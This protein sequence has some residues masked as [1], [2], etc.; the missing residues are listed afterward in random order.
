MQM[1]DRR[2]K[3]V[4]NLSPARPANALPATENL[5]A[6]L[7]RP[8]PLFKRIMDICGALIGIILFAPIFI[9]V[10][11]ALKILS[12]GP[13]IF[14]QKR[15]GLGGRPFTMFKFRTMITGAEAIKKHLLSSNEQ[16]GPVFK[17]K[18]DP[19]VTPIGRILRKTSIDELPQLFN[20]LLGDMSLVGPRPPTLDEVAFYQP[21]QR[22]R[23]M[24]T[25]G[26]TCVWQVKGRAKG[27]F[28]EWV[29]M[30][31]FYIRSRSIFK[32]VMLIFMTIPALIS[33]KGAY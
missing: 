30:D 22:R 21:W 8:M 3:S 17:M 1:T 32:D 6:L 13:I 20:V 11:G 29:R 28:L 33:R 23:L 12:P 15:A 25:P 4:R 16:T 14:R 24:V 2:S 7:V 19:R 27:T 5:E 18:N 9:V 31:I 26:L 10:A